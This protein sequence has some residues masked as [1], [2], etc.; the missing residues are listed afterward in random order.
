MGR[1]IF[2]SS[3]LSGLEIMPTHSF[4]AKARAT[5]LGVEHGAIAQTQSFLQERTE[6][7]EEIRLLSVN[8]VSSCKNGLGDWGG[9]T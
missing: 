2:P 7:T 4:P 1:K 9:R 5:A 3:I 8:S 6:I